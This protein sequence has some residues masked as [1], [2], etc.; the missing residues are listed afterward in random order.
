[1]GITRDMRVPHQWDFAATG[2]GCSQITVSIDKWQLIRDFP[3]SLSL[4]EAQS[5]ADNMAVSLWE[6]VAEANY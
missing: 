4:H 5:F 6:L 2:D 3:V 1:M